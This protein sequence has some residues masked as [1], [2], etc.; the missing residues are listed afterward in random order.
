MEDDLGNKVG[1]ADAGSDHYRNEKMSNKGSGE[2]RTSR[3]VGIITTVMVGII[4]TSHSHSQTE[5]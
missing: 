1:T 2:C 3:N 4:D 5:A